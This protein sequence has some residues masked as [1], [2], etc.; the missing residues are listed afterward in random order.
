[1]AWSWGTVVLRIGVPFLYIHSFKEI[2]Q[3]SPERVRRWDGRAVRGREG[4]EGRRADSLLLRSAYHSEAKGRWTSLANLLLV[5]SIGQERRGEW[6]LVLSSTVA[7][8]LD[9]SRIAQH[10]TEHT[11]YDTMLILDVKGG[12]GRGWE[13]D[14]HLGYSIKS[15]VYSTCSIISTLLSIF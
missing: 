6:L 8:I 1:M 9:A 12:W 5:E 2:L 11:W 14:L 13:T 15:R 10:S 4:S 3:W 7:N